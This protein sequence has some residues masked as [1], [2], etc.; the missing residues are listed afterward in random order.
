M[1]DD[2]TRTGSAAREV[3]ASLGLTDSRAKRR[4]WARGQWSSA[5]WGVLVGAGRGTAGRWLD[6]AVTEQEPQDLFFFFK[7]VFF[8][9]RTTLSALAL[10]RLERSL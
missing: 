10:E 4:A 3:T 8:F 9:S 6:D 5:V 2:E 1:P 7:V